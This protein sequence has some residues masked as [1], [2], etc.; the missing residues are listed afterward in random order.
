MRKQTNALSPSPKAKGF[1]SPKFLDSDF[2]EVRG[3]GLGLGRPKSS[4]MGHVTYTSKQ[5]RLTTKNVLSAD[6]CSHLHPSFFGFE[7]TICYVLKGH[8]IKSWPLNSK[9]VSAIG[10]SCRRQYKFSVSKADQ[11][12]FGLSIGALFASNDSKTSFELRKKW[13]LNN[14]DD[15]LKTNIWPQR[16]I[17]RPQQSNFVPWYQTLFYRCLC[18]K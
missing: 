13:P 15:S 14:W 17:F 3:L 16:S 6:N 18:C 10:H 11:R 8:S 12:T 9:W 4:A 1:Q 2:R 7:G 5:Q